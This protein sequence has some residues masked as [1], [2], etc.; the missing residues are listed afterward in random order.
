MPIITLDWGFLFLAAWGLLWLILSIYDPGKLM[1]NIFTVG[2]QS[3]KIIDGVWLART[4]IQFRAL[5]GV[6][7]VGLIVFG[8]LEGVSFSQ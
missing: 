4:S 5:S 2:R 1:S 3:N 8:V 7:S 6:I